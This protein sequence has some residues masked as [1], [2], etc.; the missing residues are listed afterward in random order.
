MPSN[1]PIAFANE[2]FKA[3]S[4]RLRCQSDHGRID[5]LY[6]PPDEIQVHPIGSPQM[7]FPFELRP[8]RNLPDIG[9]GLTITFIDRTMRGECRIALGSTR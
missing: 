1:S 2:R 5:I 9:K 3:V 7:L 8:F 4:H 6:G